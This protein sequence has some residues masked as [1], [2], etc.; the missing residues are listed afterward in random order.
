MVIGM[1]SRRAFPLLRKSAR[2]YWYSQMPAICIWTLAVTP[3]HIIHNL[4][5]AYGSK[6]GGWR[7]NVIS[8]EVKAWEEVGFVLSACLC[9]YSQSGIYNACCLFLNLIFIPF[10]WIHNSY[11]SCSLCKSI[12]MW[13]DVRNSQTQRERIHQGESCWTECQLAP[14][15]SYFTCLRE[16]FGKSCHRMKKTQTL[17]I[18]GGH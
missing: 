17:W 12:N 7:P 18:T 15:V 11:F 16:R 13:R 6:A 3:P 14:E 2:C 4:P 8:Q 5:V 1:A 9:P 10:A